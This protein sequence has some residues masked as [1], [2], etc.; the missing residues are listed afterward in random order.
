MR[1]RLLCWQDIFG[2]ATDS[3]VDLSLRH[4]CKLYQSK[5]MRCITSG[6]VYTYALVRL[7]T[8]SFLWPPYG[9]RQAI[10]FLPCGFFLLLSF[11]FSSPNL[12]GRRVAVY[13]TIT[14]LRGHVEEVL[15]LNRFF[16]IVDTCL[17]CEDIARQN[18]AM[19]PRRRLYGDF[20]RPAFPAV[21]F[22]PVF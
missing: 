5:G 10:I 7:P 14:L 13:H 15:L 11:S 2:D 21:H 18:C 4:K 12:S 8:S 22:R 1:N 9:I 16:P 3:C 20:L 6:N 17:S 19:A